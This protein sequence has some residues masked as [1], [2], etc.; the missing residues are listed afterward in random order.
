MSYSIGDRRQRRSA[1]ASGFTLVEL[2]VV[3]AIIAVLISV[4][5]PALHKARIAAMKVQ[6]S[7]NLRQCGTYLFMYANDNNACLP[8]FITGTN[9][10]WSWLSSTNVPQYSAWNA[11]Y[12]THINDGPDSYTFY[13]LISHYLPNYAYHANGQDSPSFACFYCPAAT[14]ESVSYQYSYDFTCIGAFNSWNLGC[15]DPGPPPYGPGSVPLKMTMTRFPF[16]SKPRIPLA[17]DLS[18][19]KYGGLQADYINHLSNSAQTNYID[20]KNQLYIDGHVEWL[21]WTPPESNPP[22]DDYN[23]ELAD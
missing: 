1:S 21:P 18:T 11:P 23:L 14:P 10:S 3:L 19:V 8:P 17:C 6:C 16:D 5:L 7:S 2:L 4:L 20:G 12:Q 13:G 22:F 15:K 9:Y